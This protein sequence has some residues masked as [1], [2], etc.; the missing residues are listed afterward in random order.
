MKYG[1]RA[2]VQLVGAPEGICILIDDDGPGIPGHLAEE[3]F[4]PFRRLA[5]TSHEIEGTGLGLSI[6]RSIVRGLGGEISLTNLPEGGLRVSLQVR[7]KQ[8][9]GSKGCS[10]RTRRRES[11]CDNASRVDDNAFATYVFSQG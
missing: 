8:A 5:T 11:A 10:G 7:R 9:I 6:A 2:R 1:V 3:A 4:R